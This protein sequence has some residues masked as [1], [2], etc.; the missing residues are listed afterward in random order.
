MV[1]C[2]APVKVAMLAHAKPHNSGAH[3]SGVVVHWTTSALRAAGLRNSGFRALPVQ[4]LALVP[5]VK[6][7]SHLMRRLGKKSR[8][9]MTCQNLLQ[10]KDVVCRTMQKPSTLQRRRI[11]QH[12]STSCIVRTTVLLAPPCVNQSMGIKH[13]W[14][15]DLEAIDY[16][17]MCFHHGDSLSIGSRITE[18]R[19]R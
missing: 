13:S 11:P 16:L 14:Q 3:A 4:R 2:C 9:Q 1:S 12:N 5:L 18:R 17:L 10:N 15:E 7:T 6:F 8:L 19:I